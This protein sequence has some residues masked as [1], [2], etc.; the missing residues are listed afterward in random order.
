MSTM[1]IQ[2]IKQV[3][4]MVK[5]HVVVA[6]ALRH[7]Q[8]HSQF[9]IQTIFKNVAA[10]NRQMSTERFFLVITDLFCNRS[11][12]KRYESVHDGAGSKTIINHR[13]MNS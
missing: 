8:H 6:L 5:R 2:Q 11:V 1:N 3:S 4:D 12:T 13:T 10:V 9:R 7:L